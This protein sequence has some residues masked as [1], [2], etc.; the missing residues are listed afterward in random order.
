M[1]K[2]AWAGAAAK[3]DGKLKF[4]DVGD[5]MRFE[6]EASPSDAGSE[7]VGVYL[8]D[9]GYLIGYKSRPPYVFEVEMTGEW[10]GKTRYMNTGR[11]KVVP[12]FGKAPH[13]FVAFVQDRSGAVSYT[14]KVIRRHPR[15]FNPSTRP[16]EGV[17]QKIPGKLTLWRYDEG[18]QGVS[19][20]DTSKG[21]AYA[22]SGQS[23]RVE[24]D[25][26]C[27]VSEL[28]SIMP[29]EWINYTVDIKTAGKYRIDMRYG[30]AMQGHHAVYVVLDGN[31][32][33]ALTFDY[34]DDADSW[35]LNKT[36]A[37]DD[38]EL[39]SG[40]HVISLYSHA[41]LNIGTLNFSCKAE[42]K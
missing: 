25:V 27:T 16:F 29:G 26:D 13:S 17:A 2:I 41:Q 31:V 37:I 20:F 8:Y 38:V 15:F 24:G 34:T 3:D 42:E 32:V 36:V 18:G 11:Q 28:A 22:K 19:Y 35:A 21:N 10:Y 14:P 1:P 30:T 7:L 40:R 6:V 5:K 23:R 9:A 4:F 33:G 39:P 12:D